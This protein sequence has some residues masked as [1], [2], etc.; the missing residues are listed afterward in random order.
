MLTLDIQRATAAQCPGDG[1]LRRAVEQA[2]LV[3]A[4]GERDWELSLRLVDCAEMQELN[5]RYRDRDRPTNVLSFAAQLPADID[6]PLLGDVV[7]CAPVV[8]REAAD[9]RKTPAAHWGHVLIHGVL[10]LL[11]F[12]HERSADAQ[13]MEAAERR[14]LAA[15]GWP[16]PYA[17]PAAVRM[18]A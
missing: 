8:C 4:A 7:I 10:H 17:R 18:P 9:Q 12:D 5:R 15:L 3:A 13:R 1:P 11:G 14:A 16:D 6:V 2:L